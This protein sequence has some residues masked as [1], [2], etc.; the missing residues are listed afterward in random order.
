MINNYKNIEITVNNFTATL[1]LNRPERH[2]ALNPDLMKETIHFFASVNDDDRV[3]F[4]IIRGKGKSFCA[5]ADLNWMNDSANLSEE[6]NLKDSQLLTDFF[7]AIYNCRKVVIG[8]GHGNIFGGG[9]GL[10]AVCDFAYAL[11]N[12][13]FS[14]SETR[15]GLIAATITPYML[16]KLHPSVYKELIFTAKPYNG[17][18]AAK[19]GLLNKSFETLN[20]LDAYLIETVEQMLK[21][22]PQSLIGS[23]KLI[24]D[25]SNPKKADK[26]MGQI[27][28]ILADV[29]VTAEAKEGF[30]AFLEKRK[31]NW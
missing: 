17:V 19:I 7:S 29:R 11:N 13:R 26:V 23:K 2:N 10:L 9:N 1:W 31:P 27:P 21:A 16:N 3:R 24:H 15:L 28:K 14:L 20:E 8:I 30:A 22:G 25:L 5:G 4:I 18:E 12:A 6:E